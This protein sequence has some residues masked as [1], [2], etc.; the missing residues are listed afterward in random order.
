M[1]QREHPEQAIIGLK[2]AICAGILRMG[3]QGT[4]EHMEKV[5]EQALANNIYT[6]KY[7]ER[8]FKRSD[9][10]VD[11]HENCNPITHENIRG[12]KYYS[13]AEETANRMFDHA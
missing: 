7:F 11:G 6:H 5:C 8:L 4:R 12:Q 2:S 9:L 13:L 1:E 3:G 10:P